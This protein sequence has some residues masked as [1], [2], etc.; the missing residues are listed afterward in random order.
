MRLS[1]ALSKRIEEEIANLTPEPIGHINY[2]GILHRALPVF[3]TL[4][5]VWLLRPDGSLWKSDAELANPL[6]P[7]PNSLDTIAL[8]AAVERYP[9]LR[10][11]LPSRPAEAVDCV[12]C[13]GC[14][15]TGPGNALF[16]RTCNA[17]GWCPG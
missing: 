7:L 10:E 11:A 1:E 3:G 16:C 14:G 6:E 12:N 13:G 8:V 5:E 2:D 9:W 4:G 17:L 15:R